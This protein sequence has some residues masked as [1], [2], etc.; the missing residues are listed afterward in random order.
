MAQPVIQVKDIGVIFNAGKEN[1]SHGLRHINLEIYPQEYIIFFG[2]SGCG[3]STLLYSISGLLTPSYGEIVVNG[4]DIGKLGPQEKSEFRRHEIGMVFQAFYLIPTLT[5]LDNVCLQRIFQGEGLKERRRDTMR[6]LQRFQIS[7]QAD[8]YPS[9]LSGGQQQRVAISRALV[10]DPGIILADEPVGNLDSVSSE[11]A[12]RTLKDLNEVDKKTIILVT[13][14]PSHLQY[15]DRIF[16]MSDGQIIE[17][18]VQNEKRQ[19]KKEG[20][21]GVFRM[22]KDKAKEVTEF[23]KT[24]MELRIL[25]RTFQGLSDAQG[26]VLLVPFKA[27]QLLAHLINEFTTRQREA[28]ERYFKELLFETIDSKILLDKLDASYDD[29]GAGWNR[30]RA[31]KVVRRAEDILRCVGAFMEGEEKGLGAL[32]THLV[33]AFSLKLDEKQSNRLNTILRMRVINQLERDQLYRWLDLPF[34]KGGLALRSNVAERVAEEVEV[35][36]LLKY[37]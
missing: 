9:Q 7:E 13:H 26:S 35:V 33:Q 10:N 19:E 24:P 22:N 31:E 21:E 27:K 37:S 1:E 20:E 15:A 36:M 28:A 2:P 17:E 6:L 30:W 8:K 11:N 16:K 14:D 23:E 29:G 25:M 18:I 12:M 5:I 3:K 4:K 34:D 32:H